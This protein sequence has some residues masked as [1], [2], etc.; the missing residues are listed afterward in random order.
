MSDKH[1][2]HSRA[3]KQDV[4]SAP[5]KPFSIAPF[6]P[7]IV[8]WTTTHLER[9]VLAIRDTDSH[10]IAA[11]K[12]EE[13]AKFRRAFGISESHVEGERTCG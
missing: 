5:Q 1:A 8:T 2:K 10:L 3:V 6:M 9:L 4:A 7:F 12:E 11:K 13:N